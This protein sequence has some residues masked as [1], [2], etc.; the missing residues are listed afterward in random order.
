MLKKIAFATAMIASMGTA[1]AYQ[2]EINAA[3]EKTD[4]DNSEGIDTF[5]IGGKYYLNGVNSKN[6][7]LAEAAFL[8][9]ASNIGLAYANAS[10]DDEGYELEIDT[11]GINGEFF[12]PNSQFY[13]AGSINR[14]E[15]TVETDFFKESEDNTGYAF[16][17]G[18]LPINGLLLAAGVSKENIDAAQAS[19]KGFINSFS[20]AAALDDETAFT[21]RA[22]Y[23]TL[24][25]NHFANFEAS[26]AMGDETAYG[27][28]ADLYLDPTLSVGVLINDATLEDFDTVFSVRAQ[29]FF[30]PAIAAGLNYTT[31]DGADSFGINGTF[32][33]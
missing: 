32:R 29:K 16:E 15:V 26:T 21:L 14:A 7:P 18:Y 12:I 31:T 8:D 13:F 3:Y 5:S 28:A 22:K 24:I 33:F 11:I 20:T 4:L 23:V 9:K 17:A 6:H 19:K 2:A 1:H 30:S 27:V 10:T 25:G